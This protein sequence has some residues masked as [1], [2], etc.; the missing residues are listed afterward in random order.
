MEQTRLPE[1]MVFG[2][3]IGTRSI[4]GSVG[5]LERDKFKV[6]AHCVK[7][8]DTRAMMD[9]Q[10]HDIQKVGASIS[11]V[12]N[13]LERQ[14][15]RELQDVCIAAAGRVLKTVTVHV[16]M[17]F[18]QEETVDGE[19]IYSL[20]LSG[21]EKAYDEIHKEKG[22]ISFFCVGYTVVK[23][24]LNHYMIGNLEG[25][26]AKSISADVLATFLPDEVVEDLYTSVQMA[27]LQVANLTLEPIAAINVAIPQ[28]YRLLNIALV[29]VGAGT[30]DICITKDG[31]IVAYGMIPHAGDEITE[32]LV[33]KYLVD[34]D[35]AEKIK[36]GSGKSRQITFK[37]IMGL[38][39]KVSPQE[40]RTAYKS[41]VDMIAKETAEKIKE[42][43]GGKSV[44][45]VFVVGG[46]GKVYGF[47][48]AL[49]GYLKLAEARVALR[50]EEVLGD[51][52]FLQEGIKKDPLLVT[53]IGICMNFYDQ[54]NNFIFVSINGERIK[55]YDNNK[56]TVVDAAIQVGF[57][58]EWLFPR[59]GQELTFYVDGKARMVRGMP[60]EPA[61]ITINGKKS[62]MYSSISKNDIITITESTVGEPASCTLD[63]LPEYKADIRFRINGKNVVCPKFTHVNGELQPGSYE[64]A[65]SDQIIFLDY[66][67]VEQLMTF[68]DINMSDIAVYVNNQ[69]ADE[70]DKVYENFDVLW[71]P[72]EY[73]DLAQAEP[74]DIERKSDEGEGAEK[75]AMESGDDA[76]SKEQED[77]K[78]AL[79]EAE[80]A[81]KS[82]E[83]RDKK[84]IM[85]WVNEEPVQLKP[86]SQHRIVDILDVYPFDVE[87]A[88]G[89]NLLLLQNDAETNFSEILHEN[90]RIRLGWKE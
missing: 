37:D 28:Q 57:P 84:G 75:G 80:A 19:K 87:Q 1:H 32:E 3:D 10:I 18:E 13:Q 43:N 29:D 61:E 40:V 89:R 85:V 4:V 90:D 36:L 53:P 58:N 20:E 71:K 34:F 79:Q 30:S 14:L 59:R 56:L 8:H 33:K 17:D 42:L 62:N 11:Y 50:G 44:S 54:K 81:L 72:K 46:G 82:E 64:I 70:A 24:Y 55:L 41:V 68:L 6:V 86:K 67:T 9:G 31:S 73:K 5:Y 60:G 27:G 16:D 76:Q 39:Q 49:A 25:H 51:V 2:L 78:N 26:K 74:E 12:K 83:Q 66:Y 45:A 47:T 21:I 38:P 77:L 22:D 35:T 69:L 63:K 52:T 23:Y 88:A 7:E 48:K 15:G 65:S